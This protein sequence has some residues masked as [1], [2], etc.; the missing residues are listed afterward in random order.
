MLHNDDNHVEAS[1]TET[2]DRRVRFR[3]ARGCERANDING[4]TCTPGSFLK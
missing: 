2:H 1:L 3:L 4:L